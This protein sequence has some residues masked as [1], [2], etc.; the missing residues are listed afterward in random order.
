MNHQIRTKLAKL[1]KYVQILIQ[2][3]NLWDKVPHT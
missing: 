2:L 1:M 3:S